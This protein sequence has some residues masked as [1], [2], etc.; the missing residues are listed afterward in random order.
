MCAYYEIND[1]DLSD[2]KSV[3]PLRIP[4]FVY[5][6]LRQTQKLARAIEV[7]SNTEEVCKAWHKVKMETTDQLVTED[8]LQWLRENIFLPNKNEKYPERT[9][10]HN[11]SGE[12]K[13]PVSFV[14]DNDI[15]QDK[16]RVVSICEF[17]RRF[18]CCFK[19]KYKPE[20]DTEEQK[21][22]A[23][24]VQM[25][26]GTTI[27]I[28]LIARRRLGSTS[29]IQSSE[30]YEVKESVAHLKA[31]IHSRKGPTPKLQHLFYDGKELRDA[32]PPFEKLLEN[33][34]IFLIQVRSVLGVQ[35]G[36]DVFYD[37][38]SPAP[39]AKPADG[40][41]AAPRDELRFSI[42]LFKGVYR[43]YQDGR[44]APDEYWGEFADGRA[45]HP[46]ARL[47]R[48]VPAFVRHRHLGARLRV[49]VLG[50]V[51]A[52]AC[53]GMFV[54][55]FVGGLFRPWGCLTCVQPYLDC[56]PR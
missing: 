6:T 51:C 38:N 30:V 56:L 18:F 41:L 4:E 10:I 17:M 24:K 25:L 11:A 53:A 8:I 39:E 19:P 26:S 35:P 14:N 5:G 36:V 21:A 22:V 44:P 3:P 34:V 23:V 15:V 29:K 12:A 7:S 16:E 31:I 37:D 40:S 54:V 32:L 45:R 49:H 20:P 1:A 9:S 27:Q 46:L 28:E 43:W 55:L 13:E 33:N 50:H 52:C 47:E 2:L 48:A 42:P